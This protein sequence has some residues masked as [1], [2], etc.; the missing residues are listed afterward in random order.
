MAGGAAF[1][2]P[3][4]GAGSGGAS[5]KMLTRSD[6]GNYTTT[7]TTKVAVDATNLGFLTFDLTVGDVVR[8]TLTGEAY[9]SSGAVALDFEVDRPTSANVFIGATNDNGVWLGSTTR[10]T[11][12]AT[13]LFEATETGTH[14]FRPAWRVSAGTGVLANAATGLDDVRIQ[15]IVEKL[16]APAT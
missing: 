11:A 2:H 9:T 16:G 4:P 12:N 14:G 13:G 6:A 15:F 1:W 7:S 10:T 5:F 3:L 8:C